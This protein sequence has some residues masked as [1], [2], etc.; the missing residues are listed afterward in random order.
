M[1]QPAKNYYRVMLGRQSAHA[2]ECRAGGFIGA[3]FGVDDDLGVQMPDDLRTF[4]TTFVPKFVTENP[5]K[6]RIAAGLAGSAL[7]KVAKG[8]QLG[9]VVL[10]P[11]GSSAYMVGIVTGEYH[12][13]PGG[14]TDRPKGATDDRRNGATFG[15]VKRD[16]NGVSGCG[17]FG[18]FCNR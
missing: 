1:T 7:W 11:D 3:D 12:Y 9:D 15:W 16:S 17:V 14:V 8:I 10:C 2:P 6:S 13:V 4:N 5:G 18:V